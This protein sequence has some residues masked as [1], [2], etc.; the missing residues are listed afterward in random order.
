[1]MSNV[2]E[3]RRRMA[4]RVNRLSL[5]V[6][7]LSASACATKKDMRVLTT[8]INAMRNHQDSVLMSMQ[9]QNRMLLDSIRAAMQISLNTGGTTASRL[10]E[11]DQTVD[12]LTQLMGEVTNSLTRVEQ[13]LTGMEQRLTALEERPAQAQQPTGP[14]VEN[15]WT[16]GMESFR[17]ENWAAARFAFQTLIDQHP[18]DPQA[19]AA[20]QQIGDTYAEEE[21]WDAAY[22]AYEVVPQRWRDS[23]HAPNALLR[24]GIVAQEEARNR[25]KARQY[26]NRVIQEFPESDARREATRRLPQVR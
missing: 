17:Q 22:A 15:L 1:M 16:T 7:A 3:L 21:E 8:E 24:A 20:Q 23:P 9:R 4:T 12:R 5:I 26:Y 11:F 14:T 25:A 10:R 6:L 18:N 19:P 13:R 2:G